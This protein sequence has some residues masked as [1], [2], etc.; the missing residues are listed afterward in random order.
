MTRWGVWGLRLTVW[1]LVLLALAGP[2]AGETKETPACQGSAVVYLVRHA[3]KAKGDDPILTDE[4]HQRAAALAE[5]LVDAGVTHLYST[6]FRR[7]LQTLE[8]LAARSDVEVTVITARQ[9]EEQ[10]AALRALPDGAVAVVAG[11]SNTV[12]GMV[13]ALGGNVGVVTETPEGP[14]L[15]HDEYD[16]LYLV[17]IAGGVAIQTQNLHYGAPSR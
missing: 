17:V 11:H 14:N 9:G 1:S 4:G 12:P 8:P 15:G 6:E 13:R 10:V 5:L 2:V 3:E 7:T 16:R